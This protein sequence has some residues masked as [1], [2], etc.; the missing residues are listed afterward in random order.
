MTLTQARAVAF[1]LGKLQFITRTGVEILLS[2]AAGIVISLLV[3]FS[4]VA[5]VAAGTML[6]A[7]AHA[8]VQRRLTGLGVQRA[9][10]F[11]PGRIAAQQAVESALVAVPAA[12]PASRSAR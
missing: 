4:L 11:G 9:L 5:L 2:Q 12:A 1:G 7:G 6:A 8:E 3:A 10:G